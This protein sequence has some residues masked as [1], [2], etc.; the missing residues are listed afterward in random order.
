MQ[1]LMIEPMTADDWP[2]VARIYAEGIATEDATFA[3][4]PPSTWDEWNVG[5]PSS[6]SLV[7]RDAAG[8]VVGWAAISPTSSRA[9]YRGV[10]E[11]SIY[12]ATAARGT[13]VGRAL[14][15]ALIDASE[16]AGYWTLT[17][18][19]F[20]E[21]VASL[22]LHAACGFR[23]VGTLVRRGRMTYGARAG[24]WRDVIL[25]ERRSAVVGI[26]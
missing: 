24:Q 26:V 21:N 25:L 20:P 18:G 2:A 15:Q 12:V 9:V 3:D 16:A 14:L 5:R 11:V 8:E 23:T 22:R 19:I 4:A 17:A 1:H 6:C 10:A 7:A 13:G